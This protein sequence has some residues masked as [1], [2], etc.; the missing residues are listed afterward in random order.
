MTPVM[1][2]T[3]RIDILRDRAMKLVNHRTP[4]AT[5]VLLVAALLTPGSLLAQDATTTSP[6]A[7]PTEQA[8]SPTIGAVPP[9]VA[10]GAT[11]FCV[12]PRHPARQPAAASANALNLNE[13][14]NNDTRIAAQP[15]P[16]GPALGQSL[17][18]DV[19]ANL[20]TN[21]DVD[22][23][24]FVASKGDVIGIA[25]LG[26]PVPDMTLALVSSGGTEIIANFD[27]GFQANAFPPS[28][29]L[30]GGVDDKDAALSWVVPVNGTY[31][32]RARSDLLATNGSY[33]LQVRGS[34]PGVAS[35][36]SPDVQIVWLDFDGATISARN[37]FGAGASNAN[38]KPLSHFLDLW[39]LAPS[40]EDAV[41]DAILAAVQENYDDLRLASLNGN[42]PTD[43]V[44]GHM[45]VEF[46]N[47]RD[48]GDLWG[49]P[50]VA[51]IIVGGT[52]FDFGISTLGIAQ[53]ID[54][55]NFSTEDT[56]VVLLD[57]FSASAEF[58]PSSI[59]AV[60]LDPSVTII[61]AIG[62]V[63]GYTVSHELG[64]LLGSWHTEN[65]NTLL[66]VMDKGGNLSAP[67]RRSGVGPDGILGTADD[68]DVDFV[69]DDYDSEEAI[70]FGL[71]RTQYRTAFGLSTGA[72]TL[73]VDWAN[74]GIELGSF[75]LP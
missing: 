14:E 57:I 58:Y 40:D 74:G 15:L 9:A 65:D 16:L 30:P 36:P 47:S 33:T 43:S 67:D 56:A 41:I 11:P 66:S 60:V 7:V 71:E 10:G 20:S 50:N 64:H 53:Y 72:G 31:F 68:I 3:N 12:Y 28:S 75:S 73:Y 22:F 62:K 29:P 37:I 24:S 26:G 23:Y 44:A 5:L 48:H 45:H 63:L 19:S 69:T 21:A 46:R 2:H 54:V 38:L 4:L 52:Q 17:S 35:Q 70:S 8:A 39:G 27:H 51:R 1:R 34:R 13:I 61:D 49:Q 32:I 25:T 55:G 42:R 59:N 18:I 6:G